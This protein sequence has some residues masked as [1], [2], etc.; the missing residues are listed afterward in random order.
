MGK[1]TAGKIFLFNLVIAICSFGAIFFGLAD[2]PIFLRYLFY[3]L[4]AYTMLSFIAAAI[5]IVMGVNGWERTKR[6]EE[7][8]GALANAIYLVAVL[9][10]LFLSLPRLIGA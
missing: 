1:S 4:I 8:I 9:M 10:A 6:A 3:P 5:G 2:M 7:K